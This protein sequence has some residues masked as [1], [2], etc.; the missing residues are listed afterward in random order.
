MSEHRNVCAWLFLA[1]THWQRG[2]AEQAH[3]WYDK[4]AEWI[5]V[6]GAKHGVLAYLRKEADELFSASQTS[7][8]RKEHHTK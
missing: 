5:D 2:S 1:M 4:A 3:H 8:S 7:T 6:N